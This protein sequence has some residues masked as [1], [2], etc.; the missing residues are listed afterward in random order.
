M[1]TTL[2][3]RG[4]SEEES[5]LLASLLANRSGCAHERH[6]A[7]FVRRYERLIMSCVI[8]VLRR[9]G[10]TFSR[11]DLDDL[12]G[13]VWLVLLRDDMRKLRQYDQRRGFRLASFLGL[14]ATNLTID[15]LRAR[16]G[17]SKPLE[18][19]KFS[20]AAAPAAPRD[21]LEDQDRQRLARHALAQL[22]A[23]DR[24]FVVECFHDERS[25][26]E[27]ADRR[28]ITANTIYSRKFKLT[29]KLQRIV[30]RLEVASA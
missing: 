25:V 5:L 28:G 27:M 15:N 29:A 6:W 24:A 8:K 30:A 12:V 17:E 14:V 2:I 1:R 26:E 23:D 4:N 16:H 7:A 21:A 18:Q 19:Q 13:D 11:E 20:P 9:Y 22:S 10:A 3:R